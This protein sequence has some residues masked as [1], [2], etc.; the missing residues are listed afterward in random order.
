MHRTLFFVWI[1]IFI[2]V[3]LSMTNPVESQSSQNCDQRGNLVSKLESQFSETQKIVALTGVNIV[4]EFFG[5]E[6]TGTWTVL[7]VNEEGIACIS[8]A[9]NYW[10]EVLPVNKDQKS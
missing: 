4:L 2:F 6:E 8:A 9:G 1:T 7:M 3:I 10:E 5:N